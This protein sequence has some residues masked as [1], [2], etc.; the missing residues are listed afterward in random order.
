MYNSSKKF[1]KIWWFFIFLWLKKFARDFWDTLCIVVETNEMNR[2]K[3]RKYGREV[4]TIAFPLCHKSIKMIRLYGILTPTKKIQITC[5]RVNI[6][7]LLMLQI[8]S[9]SITTTTTTFTKQ[10]VLPTLH[11]LAVILLMF[12]LLLHLLMHLGLLYLLMLQGISCAIVLRWPETQC[13]YSLWLYK[14]T[15]IPLSIFCLQM[16]DL[17]FNGRTAGIDCP[18]FMVPWIKRL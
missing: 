13:Y 14:A 1:D 15:R 12:M 3:M 6:L 7:V 9:A 16:M 10:K 17:S 4:C 8:I 2:A 11:K 5:P 18:T